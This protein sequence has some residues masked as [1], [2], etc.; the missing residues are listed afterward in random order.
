MTRDDVIKYAETLGVNLQPD[1][2]AL[3]LEWAREDQEQ[4][5]RFTVWEYLDTYEGISHTRDLEFWG[6]ELDDM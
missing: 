5:I 6:E 3:I 2:V 4:D 1:D